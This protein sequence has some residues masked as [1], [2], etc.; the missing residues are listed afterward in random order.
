MLRSNKRQGHQGSPQRVIV[1]VD[2]FNLY[3]GLKARNWRRYYWL[4]LRDLAERM[5]RHRAVARWSSLL[6]IKGI[7]NRP[8][9]RPTKRRRPSSRRYWYVESLEGTGLAFPIRKD[10]DQERERCF[11]LIEELVP[12]KIPSL[13]GCAA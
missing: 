8:G 5:L 2:G 9:C 6:H 7:R 4:D 11:G 13:R 10:Q 3:Y 12:W 1:Y